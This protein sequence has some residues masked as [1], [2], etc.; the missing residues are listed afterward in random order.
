M[1][2]FDNSNH[3]VYKLKKLLEET[4]EAYY[5]MGFIMADG[6]FTPSKE[7]PRFLINLSTLDIEHLNKL[8]LFLNLPK[9]KIKRNFKKLGGFNTTIVEQCR[10]YVR[11]ADSIPKILTKFDIKNK[12]TYNPP[13][14]NKIFQNVETNL[15]LSFLTGYIDG[16]GTII[17]KKKQEQSMLRFNVH[18]TWKNNL[19]YISKFLYG[20]YN[21]E[22][23]AKIHFIKNTNLVWLSINKSEIIRLLLKDVINLKIPFLKRK[24]SKISLK[25]DKQ[26]KYKII[27]KNFLLFM[28]NNPKFLQNKKPIRNIEKQFLVTT[29]TATRL[30]NDYIKGRIL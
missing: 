3:K 18:K 10:L 8:A 23:P 6:C 20:L 21:F 12:K 19:E 13:D 16:D 1:A 25:M 2:N 27:Y 9:E 22:N 24:W 11:D 30:R 15:I 26:Q 17:K 28:K 7:G 4:P 29:A 5:W 14:F